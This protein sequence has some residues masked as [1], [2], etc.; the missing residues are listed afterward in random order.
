MDEASADA[1]RSAGLRYVSDL[2][3]GLRRKRRGNGFAYVDEA[4][5]AVRDRAVLE[6]IRSLAIPPAYEDVWISPS[7][8]GHIQATARDA[9]GRKQYRYHPRWRE[10]RD[11]TKYERLLAFAKAL[12]ALRKRVALDLRREGMPRQKVLAAVVR[13]LETTTI[14]VGNDEYAR[15]NG[16]FGLTTLRNKHAKV[17]GADVAFSFRG[18]SG[19]VRSVGLHDKRLATI[20][21]ACQELPGQQLFEYVDAEGQPRNVDSSDVNDYIREVSGG[22][23]TA[24]DFRTWAGTVHFAEI[25]ACET[26]AESTSERKSCVAAAMREVALRL[27]NTAAVCRK[28]YVHPA[29]VAAFMENGRLGSFRPGAAVRGLQAKERFVVALLR[30]RAQTA[31]RAA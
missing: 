10:V 14:R 26:A 30:R 28:S 13:L 19:V 17:K 31:R 20:V 2:S 11:E 5:K 25:L 23:F 12:P 9:R 6:R 8:A 21:R 27:G 3:P 24:K 29:L 22:D 1:A 15:A 16:S 4:G 18:K 7:P